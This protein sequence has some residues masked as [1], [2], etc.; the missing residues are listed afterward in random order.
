MVSQTKKPFFYMHLSLGLFMMF[1]FGRVFKPFAPFTEVG[2]QILGIFIGL[3]WMWVFLGLLWPSLLGIV[4]LGI[5]D[6]SSFN[7]VLASGFGNNVAV[8]ILFTMILF[9]AVQAAGVTQYITRWFL[10]RKI[11]NGRPVMFSFI[12]MYCAYV[13]G[14]VALVPTIIL[15]WSILYGVFQEVGYKPGDKYCTIM[16]IGTFFG[17]ISGQ[18]AFPFTGAALMILG[19]FETTSGVSMPVLP[20]I[21]LGFIMS[22]LGIIFYSLMI[23]FVF[24]PDMSKLADVNV[25]MFD[26]DKLPPMNKQQKTLFGFMLAFLLLSIAPSILPGAWGV[27]RTINSMTTPGIAVLLVSLVC[28]VRADGKPIMNFQETMRTSV[29]WDVYFLVVMAMAISSALVAPEVGFTDFLKQVLDPILGGH[30]AAVFFALMLVTALFITTFANTAIMGM[31]MM[32]ALVAFGI[33]S[34]VHLLSVAASVIF[35][36][37]Y[38]IILPSGSPMAAMLFGNKEWVTPKDILRYGIVAEI[39]MTILFILIAIPLAPRIFAL[40]GH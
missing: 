12:F 28:V 40:F 33:A 15:M 18:A 38:S 23:K 16:V 4:A 26:K 2:M 10:T 36:L 25:D 13:M 21:L 32:P 1:V 31:L 5:S 30:S 3:I 11:I 29:N 8:L 39:G 17:A 19:V 34:G 35:V 24:R 7:Q 37:H 22:T 27:T 9:G 20:Y 14:T 6:F